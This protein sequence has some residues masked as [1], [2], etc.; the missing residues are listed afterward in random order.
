MGRRREKEY[1]ENKKTDLQLQNVVDK[2][3]EQDTEVSTEIISS[4][5]TACSSKIIDLE[6]DPPTSLSISVTAASSPISGY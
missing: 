4:T 3:T 5:A 2:H 1:D 6:I